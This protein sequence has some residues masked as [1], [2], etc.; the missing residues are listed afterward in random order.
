MIIK[1]AQLAREKGSKAFFY[2]QLESGSEVF[3]YRQTHLAAAALARSAGID[4]EQ[5][6]QKC[7]A[8]F[9]T[10]HADNPES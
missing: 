3:S 4:P 6:L 5:A 9:T 7:N 10:A 8:A 2:T 1:L